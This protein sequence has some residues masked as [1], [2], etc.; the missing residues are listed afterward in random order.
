MLKERDR[1]LVSCD[2][3]A[4]DFLLGTD[5]R[6]QRVSRDQTHPIAPSAYDGTVFVTIDWTA[7]GVS[8]NR[9]EFSVYVDH[10]YLAGGMYH[11]SFRRDKNGC[12]AE[13][14]MEWVK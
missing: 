12:Q 8:G 7:I 6:V 2:Y 14:R 11:I 10:G 3:L 9:C 1:F 5:Q 4:E 13:A